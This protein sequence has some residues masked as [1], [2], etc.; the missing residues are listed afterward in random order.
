MSRRLTGG[1]LRTPSWSRAFAS[2]VAVWVL[3]GATWAFASP[4]FSVPDE[5]AHVIRAVSV[6]GGQVLGDREVVTYPGP[7]VV[8]KVEHEVTVP[9][10]FTVADIAPVC[11]I[12][13]NDT[14][15]CANPL[16]AAEGEGTART[17]AGAYQPAFYAAVGWPMQVLEAN[18]GLIAARLVHVL[19]GSLLLAAAF[20]TAWDLGG[21]LFMAVLALG[22]TPVVPY[23]LGSVNPNGLE[24]AAST[25][26]WA[27]AL[28]LVLRAQARYAAITTT[29]LAVLAWTRPL[30]PLIAVGILVVVM[31]AAAS[32]SRLRGLRRPLVAVCGAI[33]LATLAGALAWI[34]AAGST[35]AFVGSPDPSLTGVTVL[36]ASLARTIPRLAE[37]VG[38]LGWLD[39]PLPAWLVAAWGGVALV[40]LGL[41]LR[42]GW[43]R[44]RL[45]VA[46]MVGAV[47]VMPIGAELLQ[48]ADLGL[49]WQGRYTLP[50]AVGLA[51]LCGW[52]LSRSGRL[53]AHLERTV[54]AAAA[55]LSAV[56]HATAQVVAMARYSLAPGSRSPA[57]LWRPG[58]EGPLA[59]VTVGI[60]LLLGALAVGA[61]LWTAAPAPRGES[62]T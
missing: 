50:V 3:I 36:H 58:W 59:D 57:W 21:R 25:A 28:G 44:D 10:P 6:A 39:T 18:D 61:L 29:A 16:P 46:A 22:V 53:P 19:L 1:W 42:V 26:L 55:V 30:S 56:G 20:A 47:L 24:I 2:A 8:T 4:A 31:A 43:W 15:D 60:L 13:G 9:L 52:V 17:T 32:P 41:A 12:F 48:A 14:A 27:G 37:M 54:V 35:D 45:V 51:V 34:Q 40:V 23:L 33:A 62:A 49:F 38:L 11:F 5:P 7:P